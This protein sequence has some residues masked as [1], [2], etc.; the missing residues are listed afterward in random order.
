MAQRKT[1]VQNLSNISDQNIDENR[2]H[3]KALTEKLNP[4]KSELASIEAS[5]ESL[6]I[7]SLQK[8][9]NSML[10]DQK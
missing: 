6:Q 7:D 4:V 2:S 5:N 3:I 10:E 9:T 8:I 1:N